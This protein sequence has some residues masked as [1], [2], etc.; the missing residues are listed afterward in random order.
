MDGVAV[1]GGEEQA[2]RQ[3]LAAGLGGEAQRLPM[4]VS[5]SGEEGAHGP[6]R[7]PLPTSSL[8]KRQ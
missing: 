1:V 3:G 4:R 7:V 8:S 5:T 6:W 2:A